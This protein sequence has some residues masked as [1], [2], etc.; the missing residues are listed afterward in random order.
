M[1]SH[2]FVYSIRLYSTICFLAIGHILGFLVETIFDQKSVG[3]SLRYYR[4][5][6]FMAIFVKN[7]G[8]VAIDHRLEARTP[9][10]TNVSLP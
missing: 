4:K 6:L 9:H 8:C 3:V 10:P 5:W 1:S 2:I 7:R